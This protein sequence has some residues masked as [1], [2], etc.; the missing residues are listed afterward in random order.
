RRR[1]FHYRAPPPLPPPP[2]HG[3][4]TPPRAARSPGRTLR[5][6]LVR[7]RHRCAA[8]WSS[9]PSRPG[10]AIAAA[11]SPASSH[12]AAAGPA[13]PALPPLHTA[14]Q[15][16]QLADQDDGWSPSS[17]PDQDDRWSPSSAPDQD[18]RTTDAGT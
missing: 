17:A 15:E 1:P 12:P 6:L 2:L 10:D 11:W 8:C 14:D 3:T 5:C 7:P 16:F 13:T 4:A 9:D 18:A